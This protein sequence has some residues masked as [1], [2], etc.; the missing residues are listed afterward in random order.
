LRA[1]SV[2]AEGSAPVGFTRFVDTV[3]SQYAL[4]I[5]TALL[6]ARPDGGADPAQAS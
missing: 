1:T 2:R 4:A 5:V 6:R 3:A